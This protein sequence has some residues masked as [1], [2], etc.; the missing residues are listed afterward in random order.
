MP[1]RSVRGHRAPRIGQGGAISMM[2]T[3]PPGWG[4]ALLVVC[5]IGRATGLVA[6]TAR[7]SA[8]TID[9]LRD[10]GF[11][12]V[13]NFLTTADVELLRKDVTHLSGSGQFRAAGVGDAGTNRIADEVRRCEQC[14][15]YPRGKYE[16]QGLGEARQMVYSVLDSVR[17]DLQAGTSVEL[18]PL[19]TEGAYMSYPNG[20]FYRRHIDSYPGTPQEIR[21]FSYLLYCNPEWQ[22]AD[23]GC[24]RIHLD[25]GLEVAPASAP[26]RFHDVEPR[27]G[28]LVLFRSDVPH[29]VL[30]T[31]ASRLAIAGW[32]NAPPKGS[33]TRRSLIAAL[34]GAVAVGS[35]LKFG[36]GLLRGSTD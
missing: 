28:T 16:S 22:P 29:E 13:P 19:L 25:G 14:F 2:W 24:L 33:S 3:A 20:G 7:L 35:V 15:L 26:P 21:K 36:S 27:A 32:F 30:D 5:S 1:R 10:T 18:E 34:G 11:A 23:G 17:N 6:P 8:A 12:V 31:A 9:T 4:R